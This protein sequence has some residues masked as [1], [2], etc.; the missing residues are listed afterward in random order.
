MPNTLSNR[1]FMPDRVFPRLA[2]GVFTPDERV[3]AN[4]S[5]DVALRIEAGDEDLVFQPVVDDIDVVYYYD[6][7]DS[8]SVVR[9]VDLKAWNLTVKNLDEHARRN[10]E[11]QL[12]DPEQTAVMSFDEGRFLIMGEFVAGLLLLDDL[13]GVRRF[14]DGVH[15]VCSMYVDTVFV[16]NGF[17]ADDRE[18]FAECIEAYRKEHSENDSHY[19]TEAIFHRVGGGKWVA[20]PPALSAVN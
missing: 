18:W 9:Y 20:M 11:A 3:K 12:R 5:G 16:S 1:Q 7:G 8:W 2:R 15:Y 19:L 6:E 10:I 14:G 4:I 17:E 13:A